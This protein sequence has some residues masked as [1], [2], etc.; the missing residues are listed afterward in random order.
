VEAVRAY[1]PGLAER[2]RFWSMVFIPTVAAVVVVGP[3]FDRSPV[4]L[5]ITA[6]T[7]S[8]IM[9]GALISSAAIEH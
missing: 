1:E 6:F 3:F 9:A 2:V 7:F 4:F 8:L 5:T